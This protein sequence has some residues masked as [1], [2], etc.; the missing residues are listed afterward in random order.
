MHPPGLPAA[1]KL[2]AEAEVIKVCAALCCAVLCCAALRCAA[3]CCAVLCCAVLCCAY[4]SFACSHVVVLLYSV[5][6]N[7]H[8]ADAAKI[9]D[10][11]LRGLDMAYGMPLLSLSIYV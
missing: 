11:V 4:W 6:E 5:V 2:L 1:D 8:L 3:L 10:A 7:A 9:L